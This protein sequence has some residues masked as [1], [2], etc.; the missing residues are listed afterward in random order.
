[1]DLRRGIRF[2]ANNAGMMR[3]SFCSHHIRAADV[4]E[5]IGFSRT[6]GLGSAATSDAEAKAHMTQVLTLLLP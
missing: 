3:S 6:R 1:M 2:W 5:I 4:A